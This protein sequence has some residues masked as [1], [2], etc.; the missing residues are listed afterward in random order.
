MI[1]PVCALLV[2]L[3]ACPG[4]CWGP[5][6]HE[7]IARHAVELLP[8]Q[9]KPFYDTNLRYVAA[10]SSLPDDW[11]HTHKDE[12]GDQHYID[13]DL[14]AQPPFESLIMDRAAAEKKFGK[15]KIKQA[16][17]LPWAIQDR[18]ERLVKAFRE[19]DAT[20]IVV[21]SAVLGHYIGD[22]HVPFHVV[23]EYDGKKPEQAGI[24][25]RFEENLVVLY[26]KPESIKPQSPEQVNDILKSAFG[27]C[28]A[29]FNY[30]DPILKADDKART[31]GPGHNWPY[32]N[33]LWRDTGP[34]VQGRISGASQ[35]LAGS[36][37]AAWEAAGKPKLSDK[38]APLFWG[39]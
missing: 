35:A 19:G 2:L 9:I 20:G 17:T 24:H 22:A 11:R 33:S 28:I 13:L 32:F 23:K 30:V 1:A 14:L 18:W 12:I 4:L 39:M 8:E 25:F 15:D 38:A 6:A 26:L 3:A 27:W 34:I 5:T 37:I 7:M 29:S 36:I 16:G 31:A 21:Q 10:L